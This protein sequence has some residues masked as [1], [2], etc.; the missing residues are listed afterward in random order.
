MAEM[1]KNG[2]E[3]I[4]FSNED[5]KKAKLYRSRIIN[6]LVKEGTLFSKAALDKLES[7]LGNL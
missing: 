2:V 6:R 3:F 4:K 1:K 7:E 5:I